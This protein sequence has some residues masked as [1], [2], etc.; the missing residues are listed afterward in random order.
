[1]GDRETRQQVITSIINRERVYSQERLL[2]L[3]EAE[4]FHV[5]QA[6]L[7]RDLKHLRIGKYSDGETGYY[8]G[9]PE[10]GSSGVDRLVQDVIRGYL[11][12]GFSGNMAVIKTLPGHA[13]SVALAL[14]TWD[15]PEILGT[16][17]GDDTVFIVLQETTGRED[18]TGRLL[19]YIPNLNVEETR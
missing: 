15:I 16:V 1:M 13:N 2:E 14:D 9:T 18:F 4:G 10:T 19:R 17:A 6:T 8:Y 3:L 12:I 7:S 5:T 11:T